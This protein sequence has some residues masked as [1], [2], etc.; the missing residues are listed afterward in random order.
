MDSLNRREALRL[1]VAG[2][3]GIGGV[4]ALSQVAL[5]QSKDASRIFY[6]YDTATKKTDKTMLRGPEANEGILLK[7]E[8]KTITDGDNKDHDTGVWVAVKSKDDKVMLAHVDNA[9][10]SSSDSTEYNDNSVHTVPLFVD[11][12]GVPR[13]LCDKYN[14]Y[15]HQT[16]NGHDTWKISKATVTLYFNDGVAYAADKDNI[17]L[18]NDGASDSWQAP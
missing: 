16:T 13:S 6:R 14:V 17:K 12:P 18:V 5:A 9:D 1:S 10:N 2:I 7:A 3:A 4:G 15:L 11:S 8:I